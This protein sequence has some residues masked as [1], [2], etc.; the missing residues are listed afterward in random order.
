MPITAERQSDPI[1]VTIL[2]GFLGAGKTTLLKHLLAQPELSNT[3]VLINE[4]GDIG[5]DHL[6]VEKLDETTVELSSGC[7]CCTVREDLVDS[8]RQLFKK[9]QKGDVKSF[10]RV[11]IE[12]TGL[13]DPAPIIQ[14]LMTD[15]VL[16]NRYRLDGIVTLVDAINGESTLDRHP[17]AVKQAAVA[18]RLL[19][20][21]T[22]MIQDPFSRKDLEALSERLEALNPATPRFH[23]ENGVVDP[24]AILDA[25]LFK[26]ETKTAD[27]AQWLKDEAY[28]THDHHGHDHHGH[29]HHGHDH[30]GHHHNVNRHDDHIEAF[31]ISLDQPIDGISFTTFLDTLMASVGE[32]V[33]R[34]KG[35]LDVAERPG[36]PAVIHGVQHI[37]H[38]V[39]WLDAWPEG[40]EKQSKIV[41]ITRD[42][43][44]E[45]IQRMID[46]LGVTVPS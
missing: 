2:T 14:T 33:L 20:T 34:V 23:I 29:D 44:K 16:S 13:A 31:C 24:A 19:V 45:Q 10:D 18:D 4:F 40:R 3:A 28:E 32:N 36:Q 43:P 35:I 41:F 46:A 38:P 42:V 17:E 25:G 1:P 26:V 11:V 22:D 15:M 9:R 37:F 6:L 27:V 21:K 39:Y 5:L 12:T 8:M 7:L 30:H